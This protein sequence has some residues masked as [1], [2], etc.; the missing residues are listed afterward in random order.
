MCGALNECEVEPMLLFVGRG[1]PGSTPAVPNYSNLSF[2][3]LSFPGKKFRRGSE[4][5]RIFG[6]QTLLDFC[7]PNKRVENEE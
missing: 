1:E 3:S 7:V 5:D 4:K 6:L 2:F